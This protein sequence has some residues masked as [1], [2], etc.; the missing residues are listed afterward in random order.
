MKR[1]DFLAGL[2]SSALALPLIL[3]G[4]TTQAFADD[5][6]SLKKVA[7]LASAQDRILVLIQLSGGNDGINTLIP[8][9]QLSTYYNIRRSVAIPENRIT[10]LTSAI[11]LH[12]SFVAAKSL[13]DE[14][15]LAIINGVSY[16]NVNQSHFRSTDIWFTASDPEQYLSS[17]WLGRFV[18]YEAPTFP[19]GYP[20][21]RTPDPLAIEIG[22]AMSLTLQGNTNAMGMTIRD[23]SAF[24]QLVNGQNATGG[25]VAQRTGKA[26]NRLDFIRDV[27]AQSQK[28]SLRIKTIAERGRNQAQYPDKGRNILADQLRIVARLISGGLQTRVYVVNLGGFDTHWSQTEVNDTTTGIHAGLLSN[29]A[30]G[31]RVF[32]QDLKLLG[33]ENKVL[34]MTIS[35]FGRRPATTSNGTDHGTA[36]PVFLFGAPVRGGVIGINPSLTDL[37]PDG[38]LKMQYDFRQ[39]YASVLSQW[40]QADATHLNTVLMKPFS[41]LN[42]LTTTSV[43]EEQMLTATTQMTIS[44]YPNPCTDQ[45]TIEYVLPRSSNV[46][47]MLL[48]SRGHILTMIFSGFQPQ[49]AQSIRVE[50]ANLASGVYFYT[51]RTEYGMISGQMNVVR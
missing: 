11:G 49:G 48:D 15:K 40:F 13:F 21:D 50:A 37:L 28:Y 18:N 45:T 46:H 7:E 35:E 29:L 25:S 20:N 42:L 47:L 10:R 22:G 17:G 32:Q 33:V 1:R 14:G 26:G 5:S 6:P 19:V 12:P 41:T 39:V 3:D 51:L 30:E 43:R 31:M 38:N 27:Q 23:L 34:G 36:G 9:D 2:G 4:F 44:N 24:E 8:L 16:P